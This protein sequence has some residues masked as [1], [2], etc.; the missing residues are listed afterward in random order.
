M[1]F[2]PVSGADQ[3]RLTLFLT[4]SHPCGYLPNRTAAT[5][6]VDPMY[7]MNGQVYQKLLGQGFRRSGSQAYR[8]YCSGCQ[9]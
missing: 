9:E 4:P 2:D 6:F 8:P 3:L 1:N 5:M 7:R